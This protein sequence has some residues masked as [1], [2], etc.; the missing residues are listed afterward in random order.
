[1]PGF[2]VH[3]TMSLTCPHGIP[4]Q[5]LA[6]QPRVTVNGLSVALMSDQII[7][8][9]CPFTVP[10][11]K[12]Q[13]CVLAKWLMPSTRVMVNGSPIM[14]LPAPGPAPGLFQSADQ[15]PAGPPIVAAVQTR[16]FAM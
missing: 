9:G 15:I 8:A 5:V 11:G 2:M 1:M 14:V 16:V 4:A 13:P 7:V 12:P 6:V 10:P 3:A